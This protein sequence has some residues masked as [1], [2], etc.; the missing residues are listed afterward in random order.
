MNQLIREYYFE[1]G[2]HLQLVQGDITHEQVDAI[3][4]AANSYL[5]HGGGV[6]GA[7]SLKGG[8]H[9]QEESDAWLEEYGPV[10]HETPAYTSGGMLACRYVIHTVGPVWGEGDEDVNLEK[11]ISGTLKLGDQLGIRSIALPAISTGIFGFPKSRAASIIFQVFK[12][13]F[14]N[15]PESNM[16]LIRLILFEKESVTIFDEVFCDIFVHPGISE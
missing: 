4:N 1:L 14:G 16:K 2:Q 12:D 7:I 8:S 3:V 13:Y 10:K 6:A 9:I 11:A 5:Q 15:H